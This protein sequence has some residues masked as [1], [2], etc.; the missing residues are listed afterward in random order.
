MKRVLF[1][2]IALATCGLGMGQN[3]ISFPDAIAADDVEIEQGGTATVVLELT[4]LAPDAGV[5]LRDG[6]FSIILPEGITIQYDTKKKKYK[7]TMS[8]AQDEDY[9]I[10]TTKIDDQHFNFLF[11]NISGV[12]LE[13]GE[14]VEIVIEADATA[15]G[16]DAI[17]CGQSGDNSPILISG[18][19]EESNQYKYTQ[20]PFTFKIIM[21]ML[22]DEVK[23][24]GS[25]GEYTG[26]V[27]V[28]RTIG[29]GK[30]N[31]ICLPFGMT[32]EQVTA[33]FGEGVQIAEFT[34]C[35][36]YKKGDKVTGLGLHFTSM[37]TPIIAANTPYL[38]QVEDDVESFVVDETSFSDNEP[39]VSVSGGTF[40]GNYKYIKNLGSE[41]HPYMFLSGNQFYTAVGKT[42]LKSFRGYFDL[43]DLAQYRAGKADAANINF[44]VDDEQAT[45]IVGVT[46]GQGTPDAVYDLQG[47]QIKVDG[48]LN[49]LQKGVYIINGQKVTVK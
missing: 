30:W 41:D 27:T 43:D 40:V 23:D 13:Q 31:T 14:L 36:T 22:L 19:D 38:I 18:E 4:K 37:T 44:F 25:F 1:F 42:K 48:D 20:D 26:K 7:V 16:G 47:R 39:S 32:N 6:Q 46:M 3:Y 11:A 45:E 10:R 28:K 33:A 2:L 12:P 29:A 5:D 21:P 8:S 49:S 17:V 15:T 24:Y 35:K 34:E 9:S